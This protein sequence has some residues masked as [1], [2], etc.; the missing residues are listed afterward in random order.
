M[1][2]AAILVALGLVL[3]GCGGTPARLAVEGETSALSLRP[4]ARSVV[5][6]DVSL[7]DYASATEVTREGDSGLIETLSDVI[8]ADV[9]EDALG[10]AL[11][12][13]LGQITGVPVAVAPW[14][15][16]GRPDAELSVRVERML[17]GADGRLRMSGQ[18]AVRRDAGGRAETI[19][20]FDIAVPVAGTDPLALAAAHGVA[21]RQLSEEIAPEL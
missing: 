5:I 10:N 12:R 2:K 13:N 20:R 7:P 19:R 17:A 6:G 21:W 3:A 8:W 15:L 14:P 9:P 11:V 18:F 16:D 4:A 1:M